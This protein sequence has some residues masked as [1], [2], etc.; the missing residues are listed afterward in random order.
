MHANN[1]AASGEAEAVADV[2]GPASSPAGN[3]RGS[4]QLHVGQA[5]PQSAGH[6]GPMRTLRIGG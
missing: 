2:H 3:C 4:G 5:Q 6:F 1:A